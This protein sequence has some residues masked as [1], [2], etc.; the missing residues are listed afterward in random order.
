MMNL[1]F[2]H[3]RSSSPR[4]KTGVLS[5]RF[6]WYMGLV[7]FSITVLLS[8]LAYFYLASVEEQEHKRVMKTMAGQLSASTENTIRSMDR[9]LVSYAANTTMKNLFDTQNANMTQME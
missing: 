1:P 9:I 7:L 8:V 6:F 3:H 2:F 5:F 4:R